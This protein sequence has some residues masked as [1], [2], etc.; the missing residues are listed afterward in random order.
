M[1]LASSLARTKWSI[2]VLAQDFSFTAGM[3]GSFSGWNDQNARC[4]GVITLPGELLHHR[5]L[6]FRP[7][8]AHFY[9]FRERLNFRGLQLAALRHFEVA[10][11]PHS[12]DQ[13]AL[14]GIS[15]HHGG[16]RLSTL[17]QP[18]ARVHAQPAHLGRRV[19]VVAVL[20]Q[21]R[22]YFVLKEVGVLCNREDGAADGGRKR[23][24]GK[25]PAQTRKPESEQIR[26]HTSCRPSNQRPFGS[27]LH[28]S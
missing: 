11:L 7:R 22:P 17:Q 12:L 21:D 18:L 19:A 9:P 14:V 2:F 1:P 24:L 3:A 5:G 15:G 6:R 4:S 23:V 10:G 20:R 28:T 25:A 13:Q 8:R 27:I 26:W 16:T